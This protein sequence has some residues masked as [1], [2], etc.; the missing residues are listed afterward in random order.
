MSFEYMTFPNA[1]YIFMFNLCFRHKDILYYPRMT[2]ELI[3]TSNMDG[4]YDTTLTRYFVVDDKY[5]T[6]AI[7]DI[8]IETKK[9]YIII[10]VT[11]RYVEEIGH[12][13]LILIDQIRKEIIYFDP[14]NTGMVIKNKT[15][16]Q[17]MLDVVKEQEMLSI[18]TLRERMKWD[19]KQDEY[20]VKSLIRT[21]LECQVFIEGSRNANMTKYDTVTYDGYCVPMSFYILDAILSYR[22][23]CTEKGICLDHFVKHFICNAQLIGVHSLIT[24]QET[25]IQFLS[26]HTGLLAIED[27]R[28]HEFAT[29]VITSEELER[30][31]VIDFKRMCR[32]QPLAWRNFQRYCEYVM[33]EFRDERCTNRPNKIYDDTKQEHNIYGW[34]TENTD[35][36]LT[37]ILKDFFNTIP[38]EGPPPTTTT[39]SS[40]GGCIIG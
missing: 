13:C 34:S 16:K 37:N 11:I 24:D 17:W 4:K 29:G 28:E 2:L 20:N 21:M 31:I 3:C 35:I 32:L 12:Q 19:E 9:Q 8:R 36:E 39:T 5:Y 25:Y 1:E 40:G 27:T 10:D 14:M 38:K 33:T 22:N 6:C 26:G 18:K 15:N 7:D 23:A 30:S